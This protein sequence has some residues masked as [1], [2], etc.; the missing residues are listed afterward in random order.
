MHN[1]FVFKLQSGPR[2]TPGLFLLLFTCGVLCR[3]LSPCAGET[4]CVLPDDMVAWWRS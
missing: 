1:P 3:P 4:P 2:H